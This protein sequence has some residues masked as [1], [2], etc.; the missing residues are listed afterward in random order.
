[1][2]AILSDAGTEARM[3]GNFIIA[4]RFLLRIFAFSVFA[5]CRVAHR[6]DDVAAIPKSQRYQQ[7]AEIAVANGLFARAES[8]NGAP[9]VA[10]AR[11][12]PPSRPVGYSTDLQINSE[13]ANK[14]R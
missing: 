3:T 14:Q 8:I 5:F 10:L 4:G 6:C 13:F 11:W 2:R 7:T 9:T 12:T 1:M